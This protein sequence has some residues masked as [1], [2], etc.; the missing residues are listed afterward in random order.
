[1]EGKI[2]G[3]STEIMLDSGSSVSLLR[4]E[5][6]SRLKGITRQQPPQKLK[7]V[8]A[9][10]EALPIVDYVE[11]TVVLGNAEMKHHFVVV[12]DLITPVIV[13]VDF[14]QDK[15]LILDFTTTPVT[16]TPA[17]KKR[18]NENRKQKSCYIPLELAPIWE[19]EKQR[20]IKFCAALSV[21]DDNKEDI[22]GCAIPIFDDRANFEFPEFIKPC[23]NSTVHEFKDL[24]IKTPGTT[25]IT[26]HK[27]TTN[28]PPVRVPP[29][30]I[31]AHYRTEVESQIQHMLQK[32]IIE[33]SSSSWM[34]P[35]VYARK[36]SGELRICV[37]YRELNKRTHKDAYPLPLVDEVQDRLFQVQ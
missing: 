31:P 9:S 6:V 13:G 15:G 29:R 36:K 28:G 37:D 33:E 3:V 18:S 12:K 35:A 1:M 25:N 4:Q 21:V 27:I 19:A 24:F 17:G 8:T 26:C 20:R 14:L 10:G 30:R 11:A 16:V 7:L 34:A 5:L 2:A 32:G 23:F 22:E